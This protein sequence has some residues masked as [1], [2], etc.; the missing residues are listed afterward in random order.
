MVRAGRVA[1]ADLVLVGTVDERERSIEVYAR[2]VEPD[3]AE[4]LVEKD[5]FHE[6]KSPANLAFLMRG[7]ADK[8]RQGFPLLEGRVAAVEGDELLVDFAGHE[9]RLARKLVLFRE[10]PPA[11]SADGEVVGL[12]AVPLGEAAVRVIDGPRVRATLSAEVDA[13]PGDKVITK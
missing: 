11:G 4:I 9:L 13:A 8:L 6:D 7:L 10:A 3:T 5:A 1:P 12:D 2:I